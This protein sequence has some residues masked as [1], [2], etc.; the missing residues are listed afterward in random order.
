MKA[1]K[2]TIG[3]Q[4]DTSVPSKVIINLK[5][6]LLVYQKLIRPSKFL[7]TGLKNSTKTY[8]IKTFKIQGITFCN[9]DW[10]SKV[11]YF[12]DHVTTYLLHNFE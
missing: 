1:Q 5:K 8:L 9:D 10:K 12:S 3:E 4:R 11:L 6:K 7:L 2:F